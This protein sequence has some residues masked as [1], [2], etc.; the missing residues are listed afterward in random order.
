M[1]KRKECLL[2]IVNMYIKKGGDSMLTGDFF[3]DVYDCKHVHEK[4]LGKC[5]KRTKV[6]EFN[7]YTFQ[8]GFHEKKDWDC[9]AQ[10]IASFGEKIGS[11][12]AKKL[13]KDWNVFPDESYEYARWAIGDDA[14]GIFVYA[15]ISVECK[16]TEA[17][18]KGSLVI[19][20]ITSFLRRGGGS[21][22]Y[23]VERPTKDFMDRLVQ[24]IREYI[25][26]DINF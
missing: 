20:S 24:D 22:K 7:F 25:P 21:E 5:I 19:Y 6:Y 8:N 23:K 18:C 26:K 4:E 15:D 14:F 17:E 3:K 10:A 1:S 12:C 16:K 13:S 11:I 9:I 2:D